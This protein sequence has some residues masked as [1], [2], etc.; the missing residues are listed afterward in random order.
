MSFDAFLKIDEVEG[1]SQD[2]KHKNEIDVLSYSWGV[3]QAGGRAGGGGGAGKATFQDFHFVTRLTKASPK[4]FL[5]C[6]SG[7]HF[8]KAVLTVRKAGGEQQDYYTIVL[9]DPLVTEFNEGGEASGE[10]S[11]PLNQVSLNF[12]KIELAYK[13]QKADGSQGGST[14]ASWDLKGGKGG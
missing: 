2:A 5:A 7:Q 8:K 9:S 13:E 11:G 4:L 14:V 12:A 3:T 10:E 1:E 6:A